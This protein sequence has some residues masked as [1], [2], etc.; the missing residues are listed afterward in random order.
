M[1][2]NPLGFV[3]AMANQW[4]TNN[5][6]ASSA[7]QQ[8]WQQLVETLNAH[9]AG[10][11]SYRWSVLHPPT[12]TGKSL[13]L[14]LYCS[15]LPRENHPG[16]LIIVRMKT[17]ANELAE[18][19]NNRVGSTVA[20]AT[21]RDSTHDKA[22]KYRS[23][24]LI[25]T[26]SAYVQAMK[27]SSKLESLTQW[28]QGKR[29][30][31]VIDEALDIIQHDQV[32]LDELRIMRGHLPHPV[33]VRHRLEVEKLDAAITMLSAFADANVTSFKLTRV[34]LEGIIGS[35]FTGLQEALKKLPL[36]SIVLHS[37]DVEERKRLVARHCKTLT[38]L[39]VI[40][41]D[42]C[43][44]AR[45]GVQHT[46]T[47]SRVILPTEIFDAVVLDAT[48]SLNPIY[49]LLGDTVR[50]IDSPR[51]IRN[52][53]NVLLHVSTGHKVGKGSLSKNTSKDAE[54]F[55]AGLSQQVT[56]ERK[57]LVCTH[58]GI[59][60][61]LEGYGKQFKE[62]AVANWGAI[63]GKN[64]WHDYDAVA[65]FGLA[66]LD[67]IQPET[68][69]I[70]LLNWSGRRMTKADYAQTVERLYWQHL[71]VTVV[72]AINRV[73]CRSVID[74]H[75]NCNPTDVY[76]LLPPEQQAQHITKAIVKAMP[77]IRQ[78]I[79]VSRA[80]KKRLRRSGYEAPLLSYLGTLGRGYHLIK[81]VRLHLAIPER[82]FEKLITKIKDET[83]I[84]NLDL[85]GIG[86]RYAPETGRG[87][88]SC[89]VID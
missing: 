8:S 51:N 1:H 68:S 2:V 72:Q 77:R 85:L 66:Y 64:K 4:Q 50:L 6:T 67:R 81:E 76:L 63:D 39:E 5:N 30:L 78:H 73:H 79:W 22:E 62:Y 84:L 88:R 56:K 35:T 25:A 49:G 74:A 18:R 44:F 13:G 16:V 32:N 15:M 7:L 87:A 69:L 37:T 57:L 21:H 58:K 46:L 54:L 9:I 11:N 20:I 47:T 52:Y 31:T 36:D 14:E 3:E 80:A 83:S 23:S 40:L 19:I 89:F 33:V 38:K 55:I 34:E 28:N 60:P 27:S 41:Q 17:E 43:L 10:S 59:K 45:K 75:G 70:A 65:L 86:C 42:W 12:G 71:A 29:K 82:A 24:I 26:H 48:A 53:R 61:L